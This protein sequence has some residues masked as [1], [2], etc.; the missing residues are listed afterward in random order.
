MSLST[1]RSTKQVVRVRGRRILVRLVVL[2]LVAGFLPG[3]LAGT[4]QAAVPELPT[5]VSPEDGATGVVVPA[6]LSVLASDPDGGDLDVDFYGRPAGGAGSAEDFTLVV[7]PDTRFYS[8][9]YPA[10]FLAQT[11]WVVDH[12][13]ARNIVFL[14]HLGGL[15]TADTQPQWV[16]ANAA[17]GLLDGQVPYGL[18]PGDGVDLVDNGWDFHH[19][20]GPERFAGQPW[21]GGAYPDQYPGKNSWQTFE[22]AGMRFLVVHLEYDPLPARLRWAQGVIE[23]HPGYRVIVSTHDYLNADG[24]RD[25]IGDNIWTGLVA[26]QCSVFLVLSTHNPGAARS[27]AANSC[28]GTVYQVL[29]NYESLADGGSG[30]LR[31]FEFHPASDEI[32]VY[33]FSPTLDTFRVGEDQFTLGYHMGADLPFT[34]IGSTQTVASGGT[35][36]VDW[37]GPADG[38]EYEWFARVD[39]GTATTDGP[40]WS[41][42]SKDVTAPVVG[43]PA[44]VMAE[45]TGPSGAVVTFSP[46]AATDNDPTW[47]TVT[48]DPVS[49]SSF[50][51]GETTVTC[52]ATDNAGNTGQSQFTV[53]V[54]DTTA[55][56]VA[57]HAEI[58]VNASG[59]TGAVVTFTP[60]TAT[61][62]VAPLSPTVTCNPAS[63]S[64]FPLGTTTV[65]CSASDDAGNTGQSQFTVTVQESGSPIVGTHA[66]M[67]VEATGPEGAV[68]A[69]TPPTATD[70]NPLHPA[71]S[72]LPEPGSTFPLGETTVTCSATDNA[73]NT[74]QSHFK[75]TVLDTTPPTVA[76]HADLL[77]TTT[78]PAGAAVTFVSPVATDLVGP[79]S[80]AVSCLPV[81]GWIFPVGETTVTCSAVDTHHNVG[82][83]TFK[84]TVALMP[85]P[86]LTP[87][88]SEPLTAAGV[89][90][91]AV[92][93]GDPATVITKRVPDGALLSTI[94]TAGLTPVALAVLPD[95]GGDPDL[96]VLGITAGGIAQVRVFDS[97][98]GAPLGTSAF[99]AAFLES[100]DLEAA[101]EN[102]A[103][104]GTRASDSLVR[105]Q[106]RSRTGALVSTVSFG[107]AFSGE[108]LEVIGGHLAVLGTRASDHAVRVHIRATDG[109]VIGTARFGKAFSGDDLE[110]IGANVAV[111]GT[112]ASD[113]AVRVQIRAAGGA[114]QG[115]AQFGSAFSGDDLEVIAGNLAVM[116]VRSDDTVG[117]RTK[118]SAGATVGFAAFGRVFSGEDLEVVGGNLAVLGTRA[119][120]GADR[121]QILTASGGLVATIIF[122]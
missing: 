56:S 72:C 58:V 65:T 7:L 23:A 84:V 70:D 8:E 49:A 38:T 71:V 5:L 43:V 31:Y 101:G 103:V 47:P 48:C 104:L 117:V 39:D 44:G 22:A 116:G 111:L 105:V 96:A 62:L 88:A 115:T 25:V 52:S 55:P 40:V 108:D 46:P 86:A 41:F 51:L 29:Q 81:S 27:N 118:T 68:V 73:G 54:R 10:T 87:V 121:V 93:L 45:A 85:P 98:S 2:A 69:Y 18:L 76:I 14:S 100:M 79:L 12:K 83:S 1:R 59:P 37:P 78:D 109:R 30:F 36:S 91:V 67:T 114:V 57:T 20:Y 66:H 110:V 9:S 97:V 53:T 90:Y 74:G 99:G 42:E 6:A 16:N 11:Q 3:A 63:G 119:S 19:W 95:A 89:D 28:G 107:K 35:A 15:T 13:V 34:Q 80:P 32:A 33:T 17:M 113:H 26:T 50:A 92:L 122:N 106:I 75:V 102:V 61:D 94:T 4:A 112:R 82:V 120:D 60:P 77:A 21:Y 64:T 24:S